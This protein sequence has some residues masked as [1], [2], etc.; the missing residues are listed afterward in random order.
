MTKIQ[1]ATN[2]HPFVYLPKDKAK[3]AKLSKGDEV[4]VSFNERGNL[5]VRKME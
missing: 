4:D 3:M 5:E 2:G 1:T